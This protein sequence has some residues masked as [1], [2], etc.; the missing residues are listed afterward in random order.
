[1]WEAHIPIVVGNY[2]I[3]ILAQVC[4]AAALLARVRAIPP[5]AL[6]GRASS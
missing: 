3:Y 1:M 2:V 5:P 4:I 6:T